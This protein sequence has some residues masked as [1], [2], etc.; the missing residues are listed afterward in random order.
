[1]KQAKD[2][3][4]E[5]LDAEHVYDKHGDGWRVHISDDV[6]YIGLE[7]QLSECLGE[8]IRGDAVGI[9]TRL[10]EQSRREGALAMRDECA[11]VGYEVAARHPA[12]WNESAPEARPLC[13]AIAEELRAIDLESVCS[14]SE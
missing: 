8:Q 14:T 12:K 6:D 2:V 3:A 10:I 4:A 9:L 5:M 1:V 7:V 13:S 11:R